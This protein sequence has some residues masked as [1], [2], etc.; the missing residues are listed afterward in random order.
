MQRVVTEDIFGKAAR[1]YC[2]RQGIDPM[3]LHSN[4]TTNENYFR[5]KLAALAEEINALK[6]VGA[7]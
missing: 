4:W 6:S 7:I 5:D 2:F 3:A 1:E